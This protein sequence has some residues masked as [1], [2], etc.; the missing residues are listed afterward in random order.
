MLTPQLKLTPVARF[1]QPCQAAVSP[2]GRW[3]FTLPQSPHLQTV[4]VLAIDSRYCLQVRASSTQTQL[5]CFTRRGQSVGQ[6]SINL[7]IVQ[8]TATAVPY[9]LIALTAPVQAPA[10][11]VLITLKPFQIQQLRLPISPEQVSALPW[12]YAVADA[13]NILLLDRSA[14]PI[15]LIEGMPPVRAIAPL[16]NHMLLLANDPSSLTG[17]ACTQG[18]SPLSIIDLKSLEIDVIF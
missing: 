9:Q 12:G 4:Q 15:S 6:L 16:D 7:P 14:E 3:F 17:G 11:A 5:E 18:R 1:D 2:D 13:Q 8:M 10:T